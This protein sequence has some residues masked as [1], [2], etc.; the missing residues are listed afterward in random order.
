MRHSGRILQALTYAP[1]GAVIAA[2]TT[3]LPETV[4]GSRNWDYRYCWVRDASL[5]LEALWVAACPDEASDFFDFFT[6][7]AGGEV[8][9]GGALQIMYGVG[10]ERLLAEHELDHLPGWRGSRPV[11]I[12][13]GAWDQVQLDVFGELLGAAAV[14]GGQIDEFAP[15]TA[16]FLVRVAD[17]AAERWQERDQGIWEVRGGP[18]H[19]LYSKLMCWTALDRAIELAPRLHA[20][21]RVEHWQARREEIR[22]AILERGW[23]DRARPGSVPRI[24]PR[25]IQKRPARKRTERTGLT[26]QKLTKKAAANSAS[27]SR[28]AIKASR[29]RRS[30]GI[31][32]KCCPVAIVPPSLTR[33]TLGGGRASVVGAPGDRG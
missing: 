1:T 24:P 31:E 3:S 17:A 16:Q 11:R 32:R 13:N 15:Q 28:S 30:R 9:G 25:L 14:L 8:D 2:P 5:T 10:G 21:E 18:Q 12:G 22:T 19:F 29:R 4:G 26:S 6:T 23:N 7:A 27:P 20:A 33:P